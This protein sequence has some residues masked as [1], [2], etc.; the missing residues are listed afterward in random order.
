MEPGTVRG[1]APPP[2]KGLTYPPR[3]PQVHSTWPLPFV[4]ACFPAGRD[5]DMLAGA[6]IATIPAMRPK[7]Y[8]EDVRATRWKEPRPLMSMQVLCQPCTAH[9][10]TEVC[11]RNTPLLLFD[12]FFWGFGHSLLTAP[13]SISLQVPP[14]APN[15][16]SLSWAPQWSHTF[17][18][19]GRRTLL[20]H[21]SGRS[22]LLKTPHLQ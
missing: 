21:G 7:P 18:S 16:S 12:P 3:R 6:H 4:P 8:T 17:H 1:C 2:P 11:E 10:Q 20:G 13:C 14:N 22:L 19:V 5:A 9:L 15:P